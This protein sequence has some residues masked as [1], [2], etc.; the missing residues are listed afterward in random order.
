MHTGLFK[1]WPRIC[2]LVAH[3][4]QVTEVAPKANIDT[5]AATL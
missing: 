1:N 4:L 3:S 5:D 2:H